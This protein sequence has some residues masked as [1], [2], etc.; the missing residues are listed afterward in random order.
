MTQDHTPAV[1]EFGPASGPPDRPAARRPAISRLLGGARLDDR[2]VPALGGLGAVAV[3]VSLISPWQ[4]ATVDAA[5]AERI[6]LP[7]ELSAGLTDLGSWGTGYLL[8]GFALA[9]C[10]A[11]VLF[12]APE[13]RRHARLA[14]LGVGGALFAMV[15]ALAVELSQRSVLFS[16]YYENGTGA[17]TTYRSGLYLAFVGVAALTG[18][19]YLAGRLPAPATATAS[20]TERVSAGAEAGE[21]QTQAGSLWRW[22]RRSRAAAD[23]DEPPPPADLTVSPAAPF[24]RPVSGP[25]VRPVSGAGW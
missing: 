24:V 1:V 8:A 22:R 10:V 16:V 20:G 3:F 17:A 14:G 15:V 9:G 21:D 4:M 13:V 23:P 11:L 5:Y 7:Q 2:A 12:G 25:G 6:G 18:S 19:L